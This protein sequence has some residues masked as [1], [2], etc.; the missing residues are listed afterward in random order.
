MRITVHKEK[1]QAECTESI[2]LLSL[3]TV[4]LAAKESY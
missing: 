3:H 1:A 4:L 2:Y